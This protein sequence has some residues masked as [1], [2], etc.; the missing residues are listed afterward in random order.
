MKRFLFLLLLVNSM[1]ILADGTTATLQQGDKMTFFTGMSALQQAYE[2]ASANGGDIITL[3]SGEFTAV[4]TIEK[5][6]RIVGAYGLDS[7]DSYGTFIAGVV[8][9]SA[10]N[11]KLEGMYFK[12]D[13]TL[14]EITN[15]TIKRC[16]IN[17][18]KQ[19]GTHTNTLIDQCV[20]KKDY[21]IA[22]GVNYGIKNTTI[23]HFLAMNTTA[24]VANITN[25]L[26][27]HFYAYTYSGITQPYAV[28]KNNI[29]GVD[30]YSGGNNRSCTL[31]SPSEFYNN[32]FYRINNYGNYPSYY[33]ICT[34]ATG[35]VNINNTYS[36]TT[37][38]TN[39]TFTFPN[40]MSQTVEGVTVGITGGEG[41][42]K[43]PG[44]PRVLTSTIDAQTDDKGKLN[45]SITVQA[46]K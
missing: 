13:V 26:V 44:I 21:A 45:A 41:F 24:N 5:S 1:V 27:W 14:A 28:Y 31:S 19:S 2:A 4:T 38:A 10:N 12:T 20:V 46:E 34:F 6:V 18:L 42:N 29:L 39:V 3:S 22:T 9:V 40:A 7:N 17:N 35:C 11:V 25:C 15:C 23:E 30:N 32:Y 43:Y 37:S 16:W 8:T 36:G 33:V